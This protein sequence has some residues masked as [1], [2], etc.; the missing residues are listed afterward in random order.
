VFW[1]GAGPVV[2]P[3]KEKGPVIA[4]PSGLVFGI[5]TSRFSPLGSGTKRR[6]IAFRRRRPVRAA[7]NLTLQF[8]LSTHVSPLS[9]FFATRHSPSSYQAQDSSHSSLVN[10]QIKGA[11]LTCRDSPLYTVTRQYR[12][13][14]I[15]VAYRDALRHAIEDVLRKALPQG[16][17]ADPLGPALG[18]KN[19][20]GAET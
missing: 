2:E 1:N 20:P 5:S 15:A 18:N 10:G 8:S 14:A 7:R 9:R 17:R 6:R 16:L 3:G 13:A 4:G 11:V 12:H 19:F